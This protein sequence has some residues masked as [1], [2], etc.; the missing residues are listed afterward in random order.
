MPTAIPYLRI[1]EELPSKLTLV[2]VNRRWLIMLVTLIF[3]G[4]LFLLGLLL[5]MDAEG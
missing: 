2:S 1:Q 5:V 3:T 4:P